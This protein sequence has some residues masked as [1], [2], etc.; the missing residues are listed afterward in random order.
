MQT[1]SWSG[2]SGQTFGGELT[3]VFCGWS[4]GADLE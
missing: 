1:I 4:I 3:K 2:K